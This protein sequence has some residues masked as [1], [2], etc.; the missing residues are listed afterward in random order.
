VNSAR[1]SFEDLFNEQ[2]DQIKEKNPTPDLD[3]L[4]AGKE[5]WVVG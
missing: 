3:K 5:T 1:R 2:I 4:I